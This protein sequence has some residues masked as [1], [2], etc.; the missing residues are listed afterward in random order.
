MDELEESVWSVVRQENEREDQGE[1]VQN[2]GKT[3]TDVRGRDMGVEG[4]EIRGRR[5]E[6]ATMDVRRY[7][8]GKIRN[9]RIRGTTKVGEITKKVQERRLRWHG[10]VM[11]REEHYVGRRAMVIKV[12]G[13]RKRRRPKRRWMD[14]VKDDIKAKGLS[15]DDVYDRATWRRM[16]SY[17]DPT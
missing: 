11:R 16:S 9:E 12:Q 7:E 6:N 17:I 1:G 13:S 15:A 4:K 10:H 3:N 2:S 8:A 14:K 5:N